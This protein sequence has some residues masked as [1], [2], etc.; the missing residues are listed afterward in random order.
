MRFLILASLVLSVAACSS[1]KLKRCP[2]VYSADSTYFCPD[3]AEGIYRWCE[4]PANLYTCE[5]P[6]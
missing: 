4:R 1:A 3:K 5:A 2:E 6:Q